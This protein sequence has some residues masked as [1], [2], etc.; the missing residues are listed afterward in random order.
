MTSY[1]PQNMQHS[2]F[3]FRFQANLNIE[4]NPIRYSLVL[5]SHHIFHIS[6]IRVNVEFMVENVGLA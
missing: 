1:I 5:L 2:Q 3:W 4:L 6:K